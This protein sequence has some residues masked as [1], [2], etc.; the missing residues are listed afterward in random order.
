MHLMFKLF[1]I[2]H[3]Y[4][5]SIF[6]FLDVCGS[7][8]CRYLCKSEN[9]FF[10]QMFGTNGLLH[11]SPLL[12]CCIWPRSLFFAYLFFWTTLLSSSEDSIF[13][14]LSSSEPAC[15]LLNS[16]KKRTFSRLY[17]SRSK[18]AISSYFLRISGFMLFQFWLICCIIQI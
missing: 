5:I 10:L 13:R 8:C 17:R 9:I 14:V 12:P 18:R 7:S 3:I 4:E 15:C 1:I 16:C 2:F 11:L 6:D